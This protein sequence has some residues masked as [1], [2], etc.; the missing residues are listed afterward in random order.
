MPDLALD[1]LFR[2]LESERVCKDMS[3]LRETVNQ[4]T[5]DIY[6]LM[7]GFMTVYLVFIELLFQDLIGNVNRSS[8]VEYSSLFAE[9]DDIL[10]KSDDIFLWHHSYTR[11]HTTILSSLRS[12]MQAA[13]I[14]FHSLQLIDTIFSQFYTLHFLE[15]SA[16]KHQKDHGQFYTPQ[17]VVQFMWM[18]CMSKQ[19]LRDTLKTG[20][21]PRVL[22]PCMGIGTFLCEF[23]TRLVSQSTTTPLL[24]NDPTMLRT[25]LSQTIPDALWGV[26]IDPFACNLGKLNIILHLFPFYKRLV[27][28]GECLTPRMINRLRIFCNDTLK[29]TVESKP[30]TES[31]TEAQLWEKEQLEKLRDAALFKFDYVVT[32]PPYMIRKTGFIAVPDPELYDDS[33][34]GRGSQAYMYFLWICLQ[35]CEETNGQICFITPSQW[36]VLEFAEELRAWIWQHFEMLEIFQFEPYKVWPKVQTDS[37]I[38]NLRKRAP[39]RV[40]EQTLF[41][42]HMSRKHNLESII[43]SYNIFDRSRLEVQDPLIK[44]KL[45]ST[46][47]VDFIHQIPHA[48]FSFLSP[49]SSVSDQLMNLTKSLPRLCD[50]EMCLNTSSS[51]APLVWNRGPNTNP[52]YAL[53]VR[54]R[55]ALG[56][57]GKE[58]CDQWL[59]PVFYWSGKSS[60]A[61]RRR[62]T[63]GFQTVSK[64]ATFW[65]DRDPLRL[66]K[67]ENS[68]AEA[69]VPLCRSDPDDT[70][71]SFYSMILVDKDGALQLEEEYK[72]YGNTANSSALYHYLLD[73][74][75]ALQ[76]TKTDRN[77]AYCHYS[78][79][80]IETPVKIVHPINFGYFTRTQPRQRFFIDTD[81]RCVTNQCMY[82]TIKSEYPWQ[83]AD[84]FCGLLNS[85]TLQFFIRDTCYYDQQGRTRF[86]GKHMAKIPFTPPRSTIDVEIMAMFVRH[87]TT[88]RQWIYGIIQ[89]SNTLN[90]MEQVRGCTWHIPLVDQALLSL[91]EQRTPNWRIDL[92][93]APY[94]A[95]DW[96]NII[97]QSESH[98]RS[99]GMYEELTRLLKVA[100]LFQYCIDQL[101]YDI[102]SIPADLQKG[103][104]QEL[105]LILTETWKNILFEETSVKDH[106]LTWGLCME[107]VAKKIFDKDS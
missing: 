15:T 38:F 80:G 69:Y 71:L 77:I 55:W 39:G 93:R 99:V 98:T 90:V 8:F 65:Q 11:H 96:I 64:E 59:R 16:Q 13:G 28:L 53:V 92:F 68:P 81:R 25:M 83:S 10:K 85:S 50:G 89:L 79:C 54:T 86:F 51:C 60:S 78:K 58:C 57:F 74:R 19:T 27:E 94:D 3:A 91:C 107:E 42:R 102:Y 82:F 106:C 37:L 20:R 7:T 14:K 45:T 41:L 73:A 72:L 33:V 40:P 35:R 44:Y 66:T 26:E 101:V 75:N 61:S 76:T 32:N 6:C 21:V 4:Q 103:L 70:R 95:N 34:L 52:V 105:G 62:K 63:S 9:Q 47:P 5:I 31:G 88:A 97:I 43:K 46:E 24:W 30:V 22:D 12:Q 18:R 48:S 84:F 1:Y 67:K 56:V 36:M 17:S 104:E 87:L 2:S 23:L 100:S 49:T 29:L